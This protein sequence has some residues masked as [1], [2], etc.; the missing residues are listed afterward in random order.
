M[1]PTRIPGRMLEYLFKSEVLDRC[2]RGSIMWFLI[3]TCFWFSL[4]LLALPLGAE[5]QDGTRVGLAEAVIAASGAAADL[6][7]FCTRQAGT[8]ETGRKLAGEV[9]ARAKSAAKIAADYMDEDEAKA[10]DLTIE[11]VIETG[12]VSK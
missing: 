11:E 8:C 2:E 10:K 3:R 9:T 12:S 1:L 4:V 6:S 5:R 7:T